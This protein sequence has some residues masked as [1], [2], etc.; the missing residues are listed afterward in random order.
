MDIE[1]VD[2]NNYDKEIFELLFKNENEFNP[3]FS[4]EEWGLNE[5]DDINEL[6][7]REVVRKNFDAI[8]YREN[9]EVLVCFD[10]E[11]IIAFIV[12]DTNFESSDLPDKMGPSTFVL[13]TLVDKHYRNRR[14]A[15]KLNEKAKSLTNF[16]NDWIA[17]RT[18][19]Q[20]KASQN[21][22]ESLGFEEILRTEEQGCIQIYYAMKVKDFL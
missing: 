8:F 12:I 18:Q 16:E 5:E 19:K 10:N 7:D 4:E 17:R 9:V 15:T 22:I 14:V 2:V 13:L 6:S 11:D 3:D 21:Y 20:N 1:K